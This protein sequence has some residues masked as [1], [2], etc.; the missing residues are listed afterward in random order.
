METVIETP[1]KA[2]MADVP[3]WVLAQRRRTGA[4]IWDEMWEGV[5]HMPPMPTRKHQEFEGELET[6]LRMNWA[7]PN[8]NKVYHQINVASVGGWPSNYRIPDL[9]LLTPAEFHIDHDEYFEGAPLVVVEIRSPRDESHE[10]LDFYARLGVPEVWIIDRDARSPEVHRLQQ[11]TGEYQV[12]AHDS[13]GWVHSAAT[14]IMMKATDDPFL[15]IMVIGDE[16]TFAELPE[17]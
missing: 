3:E 17:G 12:V 4:D 14:G 5:L 7:R 11:D 10:K 8:G 9:V 2:V 13:D 6:W 16:E 15:A 1:V